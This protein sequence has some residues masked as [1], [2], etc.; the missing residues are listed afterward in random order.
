MMI[1][2][3]VNV[4][5]LKERIAISDAYSAAERSLLLMAVNMLTDFDRVEFE[6]ASPQNNSAG[7]SLDQIF[8]WLSVDGGGEGICA[9]ALSDELPMVPMVT[10][11][12][13]TAKR[14]MRPYA[15]NAVKTFGKIVRLVRFSR[16]E[17]METLRP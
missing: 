9:M 17:V 11:N 1:R 13:D 3:H 16:R 8:I 2:E 6:L 5:D 14:L 4:L 7:Q 15:R 10:H 12:I